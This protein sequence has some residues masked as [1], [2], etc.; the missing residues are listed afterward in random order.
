MP[1]ASVKRLLF[2]PFFPVSVGLEPVPSPPNGAFIIDPSIDCHSHSALFRHHNTADQLV[3]FIQIIHLLAIPETDHGRC[4][5]LH[6]ILARLSIGSLYEDIKIPLNIFK[7]SSRGLPDFF[8][9]LGTGSS[10]LILFQNSTEI[11]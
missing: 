9:G 2:V 6:N 4:L 8:L 5:E 1:F 7:S 3:T 10:G 11:L